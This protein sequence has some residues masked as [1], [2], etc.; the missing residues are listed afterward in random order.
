EGT[1]GS[2][3]DGDDEPK[4]K[5]QKS[6]PPMLRGGLPQAPQSQKEAATA[7][8]AETLSMLQGDGLRKALGLAPKKKDG[9]GE[10]LGLPS[11]ASPTAGFLV[12]LPT[13]LRD[14]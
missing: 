11:P 2:S 3:D 5:K 4:A 1:S 8:T 14:I 12:T 13:S 9:E 10:D 7:A 6:S